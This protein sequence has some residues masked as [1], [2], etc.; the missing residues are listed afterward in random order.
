MREVFVHKRPKAQIQSLS[1][2]D[3]IFPIASWIFQK[4]KNYC[5]VYPQNKREIW[6]LK[7]PKITGN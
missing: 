4:E 3:R 1:F 5:I 2:A 6:I 7:M